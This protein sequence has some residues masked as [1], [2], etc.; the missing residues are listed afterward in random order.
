MKNHNKTSCTIYLLSGYCP[1]FKAYLITDEEMKNP[2]FIRDVRS[3]AYVLGFLPSEWKNYLV[4]EY[5]AFSGVIV[6]KKTGQNVDL[7]MDVFE[8]DDDIHFEGSSKSI[9]T[10]NDTITGYFKRVCCTPCSNRPHVRCEARERFRVFATILRARNPG[11]AI[12]WGVAN[13]NNSTK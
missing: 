12:R 6:D 8:I 3:F 13:D 2:K 4:E 5:M 10:A 9:S 11:A 7:N 1:L